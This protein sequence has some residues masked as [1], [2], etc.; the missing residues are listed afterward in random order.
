VTRYVVFLRAIN[1]GGRR[2]KMD[3]LRRLFE[4]LG[5]FNVKTFTASGN[6][7]FDSP[8]ELTRTLVSSQRARGLLAVPQ[9]DRRV[10]VLRGAPRKDDGDA[11]NHEERHHRQEA[12]REVPVLCVKGR[13]ASHQELRMTQ[14]HEIRPKLRAVVRWRMPLRLRC[15]I[16]SVRTR[17]QT[18]VLRCA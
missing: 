14:N 15:G 12:G 9:E 11:S 6:V 18:A 17:S 4:A 3:H 13:V 2:I 10:F 5:F 1:V 16:C 8:A 7:I